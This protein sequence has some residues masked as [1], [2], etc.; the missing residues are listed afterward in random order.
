MVRINIIDITAIPEDI[1]A[2][3]ARFAALPDG[4][5]ADVARKALRSA[6]CAVSEFTSTALIEMSVRHQEKGE[7]LNF[8]TPFTGDVTQVSH[9][10]YEFGDIVFPT[11]NAVDI[12]YNVK[13][14]SYEM[15]RLMNVVYRYA[16]AVYD[17][18]DSNTLGSILK[19][20]L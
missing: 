15:D 10:T 3:F 19:E 4:S 8:I 1:L 2:G 13:P 20:A 7:R 11:T 14:L 5:T 9:G 6:L 18:A 12:T 16:L 17:G